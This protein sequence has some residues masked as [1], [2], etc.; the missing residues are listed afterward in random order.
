MDDS[1]IA[2]LR[3]VVGDTGCL[4]GADIGPRHFTDARTQGPARPA[5]VLRPANTQ[6]TSDIMKI[7][8]AAGQP[9][10]TQG[11]M[12]GL[13]SGALPQDGEIVISMERMNQIEDL[14][15]VTGTILVQSGTPLEVIQKAADAADMV[16]PLDLGARGTA[17]IGGN[18]S[19]NAG[20][21]RVI[22]YGMTRDL[23]LGIEAV[24][25]DGT[26]ISSLNRFIKNNTGYDLK[27]LFI[28]SEGTLGLITRASLRLYPKPRSQIVGFC[29]AAGFD[30]V[31]AFMTHMQSGLGAD[32]SAF[33]VIWASTYAT[34]LTDVPGIKPPLDNGH[35]FYVL[36]EMMGSDPDRDRDKFTD[37]L[38]GAL[39]QGLIADA[40]ISQSE[41]EV[42]DL[43]D[44]RDGMAHAMG[45]Q[46]PCVS[47]D[48]S[49]TIADMKALED[50]LNTRL[51]QTLGQG[52]VYVG[53]HLADG[54]LHLVAKAG[55]ADPQPRAEI[56]DV[57]YGLVGELGGSVS[58][59]H[60]I[61]MLKRH[62]LS[63]SRAPAE[64]ALMRSLKQTLDP[65]GLLNPGRIFA[66]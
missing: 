21:N 14:S 46:Q 45:A 20:G 31:V 66:L 62:H 1:I 22:R 27:Q 59:E 11:G 51:T 64:L 23:T 18:L 55:T 24:L 30:E 40:V 34:I 38:G 28:G 33:E 42:T 9:V 7:C 61:G 39:E 19:T 29:G 16:F 44:I 58:A 57:V 35:G 56:E 32:L 48:I 17:T 63:Q 5:L 41:T 53:G 49:L 15:A 4:A 26:I 50:T 6:E 8:H 54:N 13:V 37:A 25:A 36:V 52:R 10:V 47:F 60:G 2:A 12:T 3:A 65:Q 43:W